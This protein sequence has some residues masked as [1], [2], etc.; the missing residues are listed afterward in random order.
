MG[1]DVC[2]VV[3]QTPSIS[4]SVAGAVE[5]TSSFTLTCATP[6]TGL[7]TET[8]VWSIDGSDQASQSSNSLTVTANINQ[9]SVYTCKVSGDGGTDYS[10]VST[11]FT[12]T[13]QSLVFLS[14]QETLRFCFFFIGV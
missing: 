5:D 10:A 8:Y 4:S 12:Q 2:A 11:A 9:V 6:S 3:P 1:W 7:S 13:G 14:V